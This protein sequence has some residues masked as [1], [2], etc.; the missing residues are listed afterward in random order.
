[1]EEKRHVLRPGEGLRGS[2]TRTGQLYE[3]CKV[4]HTNLERIFS[5]E[6]R[7]GRFMNQRDTLHDP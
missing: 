1:M 7:L 4:R 3:Q 2:T 6:K 5:P